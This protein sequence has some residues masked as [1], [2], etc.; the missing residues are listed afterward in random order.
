MVKNMP[1]HVS[2]YAKKLDY[3]NSYNRK[4]YRSFSIRYNTESEK[5]Y[6]EWLESRKELKAYITQLIKA[7]IKK[8]NRRKNKLLK[9]Q[10]KEEPEI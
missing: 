6:I 2:S 10:K 1:K 7:D 3:N 4:N 9:E 5:E 8:R